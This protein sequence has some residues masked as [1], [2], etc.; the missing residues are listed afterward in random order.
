LKEKETSSMF[1]HKRNRY[2]CSIKKKRVYL[3]WSFVFNI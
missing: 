1:Q 3:L 2:I